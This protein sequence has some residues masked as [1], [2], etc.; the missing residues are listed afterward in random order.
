MIFSVSVEKTYSCLHQ[1][2]IYKY[3][4]VFFGG[5]RA[6]IIRGGGGG[7]GP[8]KGKPVGTFILTSEKTLIQDFSKGGGVYKHKKGGPG[9]VQFWA[10]C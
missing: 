1:G 9:G 3:F 10:Q 5:G 6:G 7:Q 4:F 2:R 8:R